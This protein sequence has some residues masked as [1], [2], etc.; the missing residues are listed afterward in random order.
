MLLPWVVNSPP[1]FSEGG[2]GV[3]SPRQ[4]MPGKAGGQSPGP[5]LH[6]GGGGPVT[7]VY[8]TVALGTQVTSPRVSLLKLQQ[9]LTNAGVLNRGRSPSESLTGRS[10]V[11]NKV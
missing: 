5:V 4:R 10:S 11:K 1:W 3:G 7:T 6:S 9:H 8:S 2:R